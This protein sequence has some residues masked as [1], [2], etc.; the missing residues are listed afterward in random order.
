MMVWTDVSLGS[1]TNLYI[2]RLCV[3]NGL[4]NRNEVPESIIQP[5]ACAMGDG[6]IF[7]EDNVRPYSARVSINLFED[8]GIE[9]INL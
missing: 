5:F 4:R 8:E 6:F 2:L 7:M 1:R 3:I 9:M